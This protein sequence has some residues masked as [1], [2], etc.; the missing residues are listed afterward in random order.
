MI[1]KVTNENV[2]EAMEICFKSFLNK[3][4]ECK[5]PF[6][7]D[8]GKYA[9]FKKRITTDIYGNHLELMGYTKESLPYIWSLCKYENKLVADET[10]YDVSED[11]SFS[12]QR[13]GHLEKEWFSLATF[14]TLSDYPPVDIRCFKR[15]AFAI[16]RC[17]YRLTPRLNK[18][19][20]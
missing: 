16:F 1:R 12:E 6:N 20:N 17:R 10:H 2:N 5:Y 11:G 7:V 9:L 15:M 4:P 14:P 18:I 8:K 13:S 3:N 19:S